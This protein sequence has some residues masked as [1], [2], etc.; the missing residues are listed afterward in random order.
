MHGLGLSLWAGEDL[1][2][3]SDKVIQAKPVKVEK[4]GDAYMYGT[5]KFKNTL[6]VYKQNME[7]S[8]ESVMSQVKKRHNPD[9]ATLKKLKQELNKIKNEQEKTKGNT[10]SAK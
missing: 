8:I 7:H 1:V 5:D 4:I 9:V 6:K 10:K 3:V 2:D